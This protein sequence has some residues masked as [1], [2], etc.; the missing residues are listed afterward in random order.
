MRNKQ[1]KLCSLILATAITGTFSTMPYTA[2]AMTEKNGVIYVT[3]KDVKNGKVVISGK[4]AKSIV[5][6]KSVG[7]ATIQIKEVKLSSGLTLEKGDYVLKTAKSNIKSLKITGKDTK[8]KIDKS[9]DLNKKNFVLKVAKNTTGSLDFSEVGKKITAELGKDSDINITIGKNDKASLVI[10]KSAVTSKL[11]LT[12]ADETASIS[13]IKVESPVALTVKV[14][15][16]LLETGKLADKADITVESKVT[17][18]KNTAGASLLDKEAERQKAE[19]ERA[20]E[21]K[22]KAEKEKEDKLKEEKTKEES[23]KSSDSGYYYH[24]SPV[25]KATKIKL[26]NSKE[27]DK[28]GEIITINVTYTPADATDKNLEWT[29]KEGTDIVRLVSSNSNEAKLAGL[30]NGKYVIEAKIKNSDV[31]DTIEGQVSG[32][33]DTAF[34][35]KI[36]EYL[37]FNVNMIN[38]DNYSD[39]KKM[40]ETLFTAINAKISTTGISDAEKKEW[41]ELKEK[42]VTKQAELSH[43]IDSIGTIIEQ[44]KNKIKEEYEKITE[45]KPKAWETKTIIETIEEERKK[46]PE[47]VFKEI[48]SNSADYNLMLEDVK[49][50]NKLQRCNIL[51]DSTGNSNFSQTQPVEVSYRL[52]RTVDSSGS[53]VNPAQEVIKGT[54][55][56]GVASLDLRKELRNSGVGKY[57]LELY[58]ELKKFDNAIVAET[59]TDIEVKLLEKKWGGDSN[60]PPVYEYD[61][62]EFKHRDGTQNSIRLVKREGKWILEWDE[63]EN[64]T[65]YDV[66]AGYFA[67]SAGELGSCNLTSTADNYVNVENEFDAEPL[68]SSGN[69]VYKNEKT[70]DKL[71]NMVAVGL[72]SNNME[73]NKLVP[74][75]GDGT[76]FWKDNKDTPITIDIWIIPRNENSLYV[77]NMKEYV[78][79]DMTGEFK[80]NKFYIEGKPQNKFTGKDFYEKF[81]GETLPTTP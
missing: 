49:E 69:K 78:R 3:K 13:K 74:V 26:T 23:E 17:E 59:T 2:K 20:K 16:S 4:K 35:N 67:N 48:I 63:V 40:G 7:K 55:N 72:K 65:T 30:D 68:S 73:L 52:L 80:G 8:V 54:L 39:V 38:K 66:M 21:E 31:K 81:Y 77:S 28:D 61:G 25:K 1:A 71:R 53:Q 45:A 36:D 9:S 47:K 12:G 6:K 41:E 14:N 62:N 15:A 64:A 50:L 42:V 57:K 11:A 32:Q 37:K 27:L 33:G 44:A 10:K 51:T 18:I 19:E 75:K 29:I 79:H 58:K 43:T 56:A 22:E 46:V 70:G 5:I 60:T 34:K 24:S 76:D